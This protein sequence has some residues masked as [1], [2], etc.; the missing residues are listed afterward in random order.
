[1]QGWY[2]HEK[3]GK[4]MELWDNFS[5]HGNCLGKLKNPQYFEKVIEISLTNVCILSCLYFCSVY[6]QKHAHTICAV[7]LTLSK[8]VLHG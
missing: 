1:M 6:G 8:Y 2:N 4:V 7:V 3:P 5:R